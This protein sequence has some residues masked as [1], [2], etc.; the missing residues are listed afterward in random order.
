MAT[1]EE[2]RS[3]CLLNTRS[4]IVSELSAQ[5]GK[6]SIRGGEWM[7]SVEQVVDCLCNRLKCFAGFKGKRAHMF[8]VSVYIFYI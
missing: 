6:D 1:R 8:P 2:E 7:R 3:L 5:I 4:G